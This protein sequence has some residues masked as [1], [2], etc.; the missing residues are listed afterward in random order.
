[1]NVFLMNNEVDLARGWLVKAASDISAARLVVDG[2][3]S[4]D[5]DE[6]KPSGCDAKVSTPVTQG[7]CARNRLCAVCAIPV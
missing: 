7:G 5:G 6:T 2:E 1:M 3:A 4:K